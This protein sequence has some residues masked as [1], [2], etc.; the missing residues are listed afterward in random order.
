VSRP[1]PLPSR[2]HPGP[3]HARRPPTDAH[4]PRRSCTPAAG[5]GSPVHDRGHQA[6]ESAWPGLVAMETVPQR[7]LNRGAH[8]APKLSRLVARW[9]G[10][11]GIGPERRET[12]LRGPSTHLRLV[13]PCA[14]CPL[15]AAHRRRRAVRGAGPPP[16]S[17]ARPRP[18]RRQTGLSLPWPSDGDRQ[19]GPRHPRF[20]HFPPESCR[21][22]VQRHVFRY[23][24]ARC[25]GADLNL[26]AR[27]RALGRPAP[28]AANGRAAGPP[29][30]HAPA[31]REKKKNGPPGRSR[32]HHLNPGLRAGSWPPARS[33]AGAE[34]GVDRLRALVPARRMPP[35]TGS[36]R[37][38]TQPAV[39]PAL[40]ARPGLRLGSRSRAQRART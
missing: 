24:S 18:T 4:S 33:P 11:G 38:T 19:L 27:R 37:P 15:A 34:A 9:G 25:P 20:I 28:D 17:R 2:P 29:V 23:C 1:S 35:A 3:A 12:R 6:G 14:G 13:P 10:G 22:A 39:T 26:P 30:R 8:P 21:R 36:S 5:R 31:E 16:V 40:H 7:V 32:Y